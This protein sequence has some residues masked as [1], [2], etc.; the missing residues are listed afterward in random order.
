MSE[1]NKAVLRRYVEEILNQGN[2]ALAD[3][4][5]SADYVFRAASFPELRGREARKEFDKIHRN[6]FP[7]RRFTIDELV[8]EGDKVVGRWTL[9]GTHRG[10]WAGVAATGK[11]VSVSGISTFRVR[12]GRVTD[13]FVQWDA[14]GFM[15]QVGAVPAST[16][17]NKALVRRYVEEILNQ[18][19][20]ALVDELLS[21]DYV[22]RAPNIPEQGREARK[23]FL[24][25]HRNAFPDRHFTVD[26]L[27][28]ESEKGVVRWSLTGTH[29]G[30]WAGVAPSGKKVAVSGTTTFRV[31]NGMIAEESAQWDAL[32]FMQQLG[33][34]PASTEANKALVRR[35][36]E[37]ILN[38]GN[39]ALVDELYSA[40]SVFHGPA[41][42]ELRGREAIKQYYA[43]LRAAIPDLCLT[44]E[45]LVAEE[46]KV[47]GRWSAVGTHRGEFWGIAPTGKS[48]TWSGT[49]T[50]QIRSG[51]VTDQFVHS[52]ALGFLQQVGAVPPLGQSAGAGR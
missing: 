6:A 27:F 40:D 10:E 47:V 8:A 50:F 32:G 45:E 31:T 18:G 46:D 11:K 49:T 52:D 16:E 38:Q 36:V 15:Q 42:P 12:N 35:C 22:F 44:L 14:L 43:S 7:D 33:A 1:A 21:A 3:E 30:T 41:H 28:A 20:L 4:L 23:Q 5:F 37:E 17:A 39:F 24:E 29:L 2:L 13:E 48:L 34:A 51:A 9:T 19:N 25:S 26:E